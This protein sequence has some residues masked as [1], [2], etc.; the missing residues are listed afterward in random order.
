MYLNLEIYYYGVFCESR[1]GVLKNYGINYKI[2]R[3]KNTLGESSCIANLCETANWCC[4]NVC[5]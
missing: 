3:R 4:V 5:V 2:F 1:E